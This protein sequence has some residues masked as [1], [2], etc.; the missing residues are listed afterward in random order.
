LL[1]LTIVPVLFFTRSKYG[2]DYELNE[3][4][5]NRNTEDSSPS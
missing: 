1:I 5:N 3:K 4:K 2:V